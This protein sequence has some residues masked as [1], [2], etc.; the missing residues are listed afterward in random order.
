MKMTVRLGDRGA[1]AIEY[2][3]VAGLIGLGLVGSLVMTRGS[4]STVFGTTATKMASEPQ[5]VAA[6]GPFSGRTVVSMTPTAYNGRSGTDY[7]YTFSD[8]T[9]PATRTRRC[10]R[11]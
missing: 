6:G 8:G 3:I 10:A 5:S 2:A 9:R 11:S 1:T 7:L 4:L